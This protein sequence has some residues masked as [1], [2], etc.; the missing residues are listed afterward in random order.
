MRLSS[1]LAVLGLASG[2]I[3]GRSPEHV[4]MKELPVHNR[5]NTIKP[6]ST[7]PNLVSRPEYKYHK[8]SGATILPQNANTT[9]Q[10]KVEMVQGP[11][12]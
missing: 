2:A 10:Y 11:A 12:D 5:Q 7:G 3:A 9:S 8:R 6:R 1:L 4:G